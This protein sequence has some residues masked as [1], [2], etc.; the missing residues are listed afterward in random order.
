MRTQNLQMRR[1]GCGLARVAKG[2]KISPTTIWPWLVREVRN[3]ISRVDA[4][5]TGLQTEVVIC[6]KILGYLCNPQIIGEHDPIAAVAQ[7][8]LQTLGPGLE[9]EER[10]E[11]YAGEVLGSLAYGDEFAIGEELIL[12]FAAI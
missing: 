10:I 2:T 5:G 9:N 1:A 12:D 6:T 11:V 7:T 3:R 4:S 8:Q